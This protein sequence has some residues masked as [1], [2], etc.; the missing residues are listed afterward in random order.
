M[1]IKLYFYFLIELYWEV[2]FISYIFLCFQN[3]STKLCHFRLWSSPTYQLLRNLRCKQLVFQSFFY[4]PTTLCVLT[5]TLPAWELLLYINSCFG[6]TYILICNTIKH[7]G[8]SKCRRKP[9]RLLLEFSQSQKISRVFVRV[10]NSERQGTE[11]WLMYQQSHN[12]HLQNTYL[13]TVW[14]SVHL[15]WCNLFCPLKQHD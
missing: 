3:F 8:M 7:I 4:R 9:S 10:E 12:C 6:D 15:T 5:R 14:S 11:V 13:F 1:S 2:Y